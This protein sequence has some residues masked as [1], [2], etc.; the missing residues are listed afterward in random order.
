MSLR[1]EPSH[2]DSMLS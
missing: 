1:D 2:L